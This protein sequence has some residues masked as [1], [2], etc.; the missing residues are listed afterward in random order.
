MWEYR[1]ST[2]G[3][4]SKHHGNTMEASS[5]HESTIGLSW[6]EHGMTMNAPWDNH[7]IITM[8]APPVQHGNTMGS[9]DW[10]RHENALEVP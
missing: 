7:G 5:F 4:A 6:K 9:W 2:T 3:S 8:E 10:D 1:E